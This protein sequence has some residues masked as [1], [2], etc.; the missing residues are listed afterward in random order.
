MTRIAFALRLVADWCIPC[1][2]A[3]ARARRPGARAR[4][5]A[6]R[7]DRGV[8]QFRLP[9]R[10]AGRCRATPPSRCCG[11]TTARSTRSRCVSDGRIVTGGDDGKI[12]VWQ[13]GEPAPQRVLEGHVAPGRQ[14]RGVAGRRHACVGVLGPH[15][16]GCGRSRTAARRASS[17]R[18]SAERQRRGVHAGRQGAG[19]R[20]LRSDA[21]ASGR[22]TAA[23]RS[24]SPCRRRSIPSPSAATARS[25]P[26]APTAGCSSFRRTGEPHG[27]I[28]SGQTPIVTVAVSGD[29]AL[30]AA[31]GIRGSVAIIDRRDAQARCAPWSAPDC[32]YGR[33]R[34]FPTTARCSP[35]A[36][37]A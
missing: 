21:C 29:G 15:A 14:P 1:A 18:P 26:A 8:R 4:D 12:A 37:T 6:R 22:S 25:S 33:R 7:Q 11:S 31:A 10:S 27:E 13:P 32:R 30:I 24:S 19:Q 5:L 9:R 34:S 36:P 2:G 23:R 3:I 35:A 28:D 16:S 20:R 17:D